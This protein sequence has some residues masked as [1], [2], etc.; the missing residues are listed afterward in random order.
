MTSYLLTCRFYKKLW[1]KSQDKNVMYKEDKR[2]KTI[3]RD[4]NDIH[5]ITER[6][7]GNISI[8]AIKC[9]KNY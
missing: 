7:K 8:E 9:T 1:G 6:I 3:D 5:E 4:F 2:K